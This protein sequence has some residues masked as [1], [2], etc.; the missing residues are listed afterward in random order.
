MTPADLVTAP[1]GTT[2]E[3]AQGRSCGRHRIEKL[4][5]VDADGRLQGLITVK[6]ISEADRA[7]PPPPRTSRAACGSAPPVGVGPDALERAA[8]LVDAEVDAARRRHGRTATRRAC[9]TIVRRDQGRA[10]RPGDRR[11]HRHR[12]GGRGARRR[13]RRRAS[14]S[15]RARARSA[16]PASSPA[17]AVPQVT[18]VYDMRPGARRATAS[19]SSPTAAS[20]SSGDVAK[21][22]AA[23]RR[24]GDARLDARRHRRGAR[25]R[26]PRP[27]GA[28]QGVPRAWARSAP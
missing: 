14:R 24:H 19:P 18:A 20:R 12:R 6:D 23:R 10:R 3:E 26:D 8:A 13:R 16:P 2:L 4:P 25:R 17:S 22:I 1:V 21:A 28:L 5:I 27:G 9:S 15:D 7:Y 11:Q